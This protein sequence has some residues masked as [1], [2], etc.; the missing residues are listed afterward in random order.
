M[1]GRSYLSGAQ[2]RKLANE[3]KAKNE[4]EL[5]KIPKITDMFNAAGPSTSPSAVTQT[6]NQNEMSME[7]IDNEIQRIC[8]ENIGD[9]GD[10]ISIVDSNVYHDYDDNLDKHFSNVSVASLA[11][12]SDDACRF[13]TDVAKWNISEDLP[14]L[15]RY[16]SRLGIFFIE[17]CVYF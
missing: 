2:K 4:E 5:K 7:E 16:W 12:E 15:Q 17:Y 1:S 14:N 13:P 3:K 9:I 10:D 6:K 11:S 8:E